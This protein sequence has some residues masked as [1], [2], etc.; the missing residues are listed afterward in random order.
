MKSDIGGSIGP[1]WKSRGTKEE[2][3]RTKRIVTRNCHAG[4]TIGMKSGTGGLS[5]RLWARSA[6]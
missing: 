2:L 1:V 5:R 4:N 6:A 3:G